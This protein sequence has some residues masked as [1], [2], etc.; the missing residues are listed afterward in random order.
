MNTIKLKR[1]ILNHSKPGMSR[2]QCDIA[3]EVSRQI[4]LDCIG[5]IELTAG[6][7]SKGL[8]LYEKDIE[9][10]AVFADKNILWDQVP[11]SALMG[12][13]SEQNGGMPHGE[14]SVLLSNLAFDW[15][16]AGVFIR[17]LS[18]ALSPNGL[19]WFTAYGSGTAMRSRTILSELDQY[20]H[21][22][23]FYELQDIGDA[24]LGAGLKDVALSSSFMNL[25]YTSL[26][27]LLADARRI[28]G[29]N[30]NPSQ[31]TTLGGRGVFETFKQ[32]VE[33]I[34]QREGVFTEQ[35]EIIVAH[36]R[37]VDLPAMNG[38]IPV[39]MGK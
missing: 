1:S 34:I 24:L 35:L 25:E 19:F 22:N 31:R 3:S 15:L 16:D 36:G 11:F 27:I 2:L 7:E 12:E 6:E 38:L 14:Y 17:Q 10:L 33:Q 28:F 4:L 32:K 37:K 21:F 13:S 30:L 29:V 26:D 18:D 8:L 23:D 20:A 39:R 9:S 5:D